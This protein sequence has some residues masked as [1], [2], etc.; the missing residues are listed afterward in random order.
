MPKP[1]QQFKDRANKPAVNCVKCERTY[2][3]L[4]VGLR[5]TMSVVR[6]NIV[7]YGGPSAL[8]AA[9]KSRGADAVDWSLV[10]K[11]FKR[12]KVEAEPGDAAAEAAA[13]SHVGGPTAAEGSGSDSDEGSDS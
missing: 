4:H 13:E 8:L 10:E 12:R 5:C 2:A 11:S 6:G 1:V 7:K 3:T 9:Y